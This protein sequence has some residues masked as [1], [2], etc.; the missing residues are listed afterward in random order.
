MHVR[1]L[2]VRIGAVVRT[3]D[4][5]TYSIPQGLPG[6]VDV[7]GRELGSQ[8]VQSRRERRARVRMDH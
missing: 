5:Y 2:S 1:K 4:A 6:G 3:T 8:D 7:D